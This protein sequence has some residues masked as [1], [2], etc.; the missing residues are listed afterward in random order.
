MLSGADAV[1][2]CGIIHWGHT[3]APSVQESHLVPFSPGSTPQAPNLAAKLV[4][5]EHNAKKKLFFLEIVEPQ[6]NFDEVKKVQGEHN[7]KKISFF[8]DMAE[9]VNM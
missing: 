5:G 6:P 8:L 3:A 9:L 7:A 4:Q 1:A 2:K